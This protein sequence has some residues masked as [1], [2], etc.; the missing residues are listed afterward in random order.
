MEATQDIGV[1]ILGAAG[2]RGRSALE[3]L[4][5]LCVE[6]RKKGIDLKLVCLAEAKEEC[7]VHLGGTV[8]ALFG[9]AC[10]VVGMLAEAIPHAL[11]WL[12]CSNGHRKLIV[13]DAAPTALHYQH[14]MAV[15]PHSERAHIYYFGEKPLFT[16]EAQVEFVERSFAGHTFFCEF[17]ETE[18]PAF[19]MANEFIRSEGL[20]IQRMHFW[21][22]SCMGISVAAGQGRGGVQGGA[23]LDKAPHDLSVAIGLLGPR[24]LKRWSVSLVRTHLLALHEDALRL[25]RRNFL[26]VS[27]TPI[28]DLSSPARIPE[29]L[30]AEALVSFDAHFALQGN[31]TIPVSFIASWV[32]IQNAEPER[33]LSERLVRLGLGPEEWLNEEEPQVSR[34]LRYRYRN[35][36]VRISLLEGLLGNRKVHLVLN[37]LAKFE[38][39]RFVYL[40]GEDGRREAIFEE[41]SSRDYHASKEVDLLGIFKHV[42]EHCAGLSSADNI[43]TGATVLVHKIMLSAQAQ[44]NDQLPA[45][46]Q[47]EAYR[48]SVRAYRKYLVPVGPMP[49]GQGWSP[50]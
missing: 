44:A 19:R 42:V 21:R 17:I 3:S 4:P 43:S 9:V 37:L 25:N 28:E 5:K 38:G 26:S 31:I 27:N 45:V 39:R 46:D 16:Q 30:P 50:H 14:L 48:A 47:D 11:H 22:A 36:E 15:L 7:R 34:N 13:Y 29:R 49:L 23:L 24:L 6:E 18:N 8:A 1:V 33:S 35:Q 20:Q 32:G 12:G 40:I 10:P 41:K 2:D